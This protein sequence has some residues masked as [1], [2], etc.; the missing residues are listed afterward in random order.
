MIM[1]TKNWFTIV[2]GLFFSLTCCNEPASNELMNDDGTVGSST[3]GHE[4]DCYVYPVR[5]GSDT[6]RAFENHEQ[7]VES[8][9]I[10]EG[11]LEKMSTAG[12][13]E[14]AIENPLFGDFTAYNNYQD[15]YDNFS[16]YFNVFRILESREDAAS[17]LIKKYCSMEYQ[18]D[19]LSNFSYW[20]GK[21]CV[22]GVAFLC[23]EILL[24]Q[25]VYLDKATDQELRSLSL[26]LLESYNLKCEDKN[27][28]ALFLQIGQNTSLWV[29]SRIME[30]Y[31]YEEWLALKS[32]SDFIPHFL[33]TCMFSNECESIIEVFKQFI[34][35]SNE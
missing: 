18:Y 16:S 4:S 14:S 31:Q 24:A 13:I 12:I 22:P 30:K 11:V 25:N 6:W 27:P 28:K 2:F 10:P 34:E 20:E 7:M 29:A 9:Q 26:H 15:F 3:K 33:Q 35:D 19:D 17:E 8:C 23:M 1:K 5:P 21:G 32:S